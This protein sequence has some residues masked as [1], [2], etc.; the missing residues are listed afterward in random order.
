MFPLSVAEGNNQARKHGKCY[1]SS[2]FPFLT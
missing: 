2:A 1:L